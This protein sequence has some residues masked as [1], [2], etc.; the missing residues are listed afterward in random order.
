M[1][2]NWKSIALNIY[3]DIKWTISNL[4]NKPTLW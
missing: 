2:I 3:N 4:E 1:I